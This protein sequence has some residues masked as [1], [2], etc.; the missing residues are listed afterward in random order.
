MSRFRLAGVLSVAIALASGVA[1]AEAFDVI[2]IR[3]PG[4][5][6]EADPVQTELVGDM[7]ANAVVGMPGIRVIELEEGRAADYRL[8]VTVSRIRDE[9]VV[10]TT[11]DETTT[12]TIIHAAR[13]PL[14]P[15]NA[16]TAVV[17]WR[18]ELEIALELQ[19]R[20]RILEQIDYLN[21]EDNAPLAWEYLQRAARIAVPVAPAVETRIRTMQAAAALEQ[22]S[23]DQEVSGDDQSLP[24]RSQELVD[25]ALTAPEREIV[26]PLVEQWQAAAATREADR[27][28]RRIERQEARRAAATDEFEDLLRA[29]RR[30]SRAEDSRAAEG[31][32]SGAV[33]LES[34]QYLPT[35]RD[36]ST[37]QREL[38][39][40]EEDRRRSTAREIRRAHLPDPW[41]PETVRRRGVW[42]SIAGTTM[43][44][45][46][47]RY[48][49]S[50]IT[51]AATMTL[52][53]TTPVIS[54]VQLHR[55]AA[56]SISRP[57]DLTRVT[58]RVAAALAPGT[59]LLEGAI[60][61]TL[62]MSV[63]T[64]SVGDEPLTR[65]GPTAGV[66]AAGY[67]SIP[68]TAVRLGLQSRWT[69]TLWIPTWYITR[70][71]TIGFTT[72]WQW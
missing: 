33:A 31:Y 71:T 24:E 49:V 8:R 39:R 36:L 60:G 48:Q 55:A 61:P 5:V 38:V 12:G 46:L 28:A 20:E 19:A 58:M 30:A 65:T 47:E 23:V 50:G 40:W 10:T 2:G 51:P 22:V 35:T 34:D 11:V 41:A 53:D 44:D 69:R 63:L 59:T 56:V 70:H 14:I 52:R 27:E 29:A 64:G 13:V 45:P 66:V 21:R 15:E 18:E 26:E 57:D 37:A 3:P 67:L 62:G 43:Q 4:A 25:V 7:F 1:P 17:S 72:G 6:G 9:A 54:Y 42:L 32:L 16:A 68:G